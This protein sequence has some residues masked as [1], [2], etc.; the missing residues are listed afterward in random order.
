M[1]HLTFF[2]VQ[3]L[4]SSVRN[5]IDFT[6]K[7]WPAICENGLRNSPINFPDASASNYIVSQSYFNIISSSYQIIQ[8][9][10]FEQDDWKYYVNMTNSGSLMIK[11]ANIEY[12]YNID[13][14]NFHIPSS[15]TFQGASYDLE[16]HFVHK[17]DTQYL[18]N[19]GVFYDPD[20]N[21]TM[22]IVAVIF[23]VDSSG[24]LNLDIQKMNI[25]TLAPINGIDLNRY[26]NS[27]K[28]FYFYEGSRT[29]P[30]CQE[31]VNW[32]VMEQIETL[33]E[34]QYNDFRNWVY[35]TYPLGN[36]RQTKPLYGRSIYQIINSDII[37]SVPLYFVFIINLLLII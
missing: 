16:F 14:I 5:L 30:P 3:L 32:V 18:I 28:N 7:N 6:E 33:S 12:K 25:A 37:L 35:Q 11:K 24:A 4:L 23:K 20:K 19:Q 1:K 9:K 10:S 22:L 2:I 29:V 36:S 31:D 13:N 8:G 15:H 21:N 26:V 17:K 27:T 34:T